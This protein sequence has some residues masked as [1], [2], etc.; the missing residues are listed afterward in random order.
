M[1]LIRIDSIREN[2]QSSFL[3]LIGIA[4]NAILLIQQSLQQGRGFNT[5]Q[6]SLAIVALAF[7]STG[8][9]LNKSE[10]IGQIGKWLLIG[11]TVAAAIMSADLI[12]LGSLPNFAVKHLMFS[13][14]IFCLWLLGSASGQSSQKLK[15]RG[16]FAFAL[17]RKR[18]VAK[19]LGI[20]LQL[21]LLVVVVQQYHLEHQAFYHNMM[22]LAFYG[23]LFH[24]FLPEKFRLPFFLLL[25]LAAVPGILG[26][27]VG[28]TIIFIGLILLGLAH[29][30][31]RLFVGTAILLMACVLLA[32]LRIGLISLSAP[33]AVWPVLGSMFMF[34]LII[35]RL[36]RQRQKEP[37]NIIQA[38]S[39][40]FLLPN[41]TF[42]LF[43]VVDFNTFCRSY[44]QGA[45]F[46]IYQ[47]G[48]KWI[49]LG[50]IQLILYRLIDS[51]LVIA[52]ET[53]SSTGEL[54]RFVAG[55]YLLF[56]RITGQFFLVIGILNLFGFNLPRTSDQFFLASSL[57]DLLRRANTY[58]KEF[59][60]K[61]FFYP[62]YFRL[63]RWG[64]AASI[65]FSIIIVIT[66]AALLHSYQWFW[67]TGSFRLTTQDLL[68]WLVLCFLLILSASFERSGHAPGV[69]P[70]NLRNIA[71]LSLKITT[72][73]TIFAVLWSLWTSRSLSAWLSLWLVGF[74]SL[75]SIL[76]VFVTLAGITITLGGIIWI[77]RATELSSGK[78][79]NRLGI[80]NPVVLYGGITFMLV[81]VGSPAVYSLFGESAAG[82][83]ADFKAPH[84]SNRAISL[85][86][87][88]YYETLASTELFNPDLWEIYD[89][90]PYYWPLI[91]DTTAAN[92]TRD[93]SL[94]ELVPSKRSRFHSLTFT[95]NRWGMRDQE[96][97]QMPA[98]GTYRVVLVGPSYV[99][100]S[101]VA[102]GEPFEAVLETRLNQEFGGQEYYKYEILNYGIAGSSALA[103]LWLL[104]TKG[105][106]FEPD[107]IYFVSHN[108]EEEKV[109]THLA[110]M[111]ITGVEIPYDYLQEIV[112]QAGVE[113]GMPQGEAER[114]LMPYRADIVSWTYNR[115]VALAQERGILPVWIYLP[116]PERDISEEVGRHL[117]GLATE[118]GFTIIALSDVYAGY[119][120]DMLIVAKWDRHPNA[121]GHRLIADRLYTALREEELV[122]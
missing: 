112:S 71:R 49:F 95:T 107:A 63:R 11:V 79:K 3:I 28:F 27:Q 43:P 108:V 20:V 26:F 24:F 36:N 100:G 42:P 110:N 98:P 5:N 62:I 77:R 39:Y 88:D 18:E 9:A 32:L 84:L 60:Q 61:L 82:F 22:L 45:R 116:P 109:V 99:M 102:D 48:V 37:S 69:R 105:V 97:E 104:E 86:Q 50:V 83:M 103:E 14:V 120:L 1:R 7:L 93:F 118:A 53:V 94:I 87:Y 74:D 59:L 80:F 70:M 16:W 81:L 33:T 56:I 72:T 92:L 119:D 90:R 115:I 12:I 4:I 73:F 38:L 68:F 76:L 19:F 121:A 17:S 78:K 66:I 106:S 111:A 30:P 41:I 114:R 35:Y 6:A 101:S 117:M 67:L 54:I 25:S 34:R 122:P 51:Y 65:P 23:F 40:F 64:T 46:Q 52:P 2:F 44:N 91:Q 58:W 8:L 21:S 29:L 85:A 47:N 75:N 55:G 31:V 10:K 13:M 113:Q 96:Y 89:K 15:F 57:A